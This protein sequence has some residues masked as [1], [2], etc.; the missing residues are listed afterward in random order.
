MA[1]TSDRRRRGPRRAFSQGEVLDAAQQLLDEGGPE[2]ASVRAIAKKL[3]VAPNTVYTYFP[4]KDAIRHALVERLLGGVDHGVFGDDGRPWRQRAEALALELRE[5][6][7]THPGAVSLVIGAPL[8]GPQARALAEHTRQLFTDAGLDA[9]DADR[10]Y[11]VLLTYIVGSLA[12]EGAHPHGEEPPPHRDTIGA[13]PEAAE[14]SPPQ[15]DTG[16]D[17]YHWG[18]HRILDGLSPDTPS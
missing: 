11:R 10:A 5:Q 1:S 4:D 3:R 15:E 18:L 17:R 12:L 13:A 7:T 9:A 16:A 14:S 2:A 8:N 6:L